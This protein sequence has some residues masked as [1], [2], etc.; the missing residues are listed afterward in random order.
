M[1]E[2]LSSIRR[3]IADEEAEETHPED[4]ELGAAE[5]HADALNDD[6][7]A[8][9][10]AAEDDPEDVLELTK[11]VRESGEVVDLK[12]E[13]D[14]YAARAGAPPPDAA[15]DEV[16]LAPLDAGA[17][18]ESHN[19]TSDESKQEE[20]TAVEMKSAAIGAELV[21]ATA[22]SAA[23]GAFARLSE[24]LHQ[25]PPEESV[26]D[27]SGRTV[28]QFVEDMIR[29]LLKEWLDQNLPPIVE[30]LVQKEIQ[31]IAR[32]AELV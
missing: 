21:S 14:A 7:D 3:I 20:P 24:A 32:R 29:P 10:S 13:G 2:I 23:T 26:A 27:D 6:A 12:A 28:E 18:Q 15:G 4:D 17:D 11:V 22:A 9:A 8:L 1:E 30:R 16:E 5:A 25:T 19:V 31:K